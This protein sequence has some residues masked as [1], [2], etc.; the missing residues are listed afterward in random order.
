[1]IGLASSQNIL[2]PIFNFFY[3]LLA[4]HHIRLPKTLKT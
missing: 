3:A 1:M 4:G 2:T